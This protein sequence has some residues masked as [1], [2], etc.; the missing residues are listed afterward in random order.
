V[1][2]AVYSLRS[3]ILSADDTPLLLKRLTVEA[4][5][6]QIPELTAVVLAKLNSKENVYDC[7]EVLRECLQEYIMQGWEI[8]LTFE[9]SMKLIQ[10][11]NYTHKPAHWEFDENRQDYTCSECRGEKAQDRWNNHMRNSN[12]FV[13]IRKKK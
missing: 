8:M 5:F 12:S 10:V 4:D 13:L 1:C 11:C 6:F 9:Q 3:G 2:E 7:L